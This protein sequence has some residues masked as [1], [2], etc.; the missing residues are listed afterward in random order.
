MKITIEIENSVYNT[1]GEIFK[2]AG[3]PVELY[4]RRLLTQIVALAATD[5]DVLRAIHNKSSEV[6]GY[7]HLSEQLLKP[8]PQSE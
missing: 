2:P 5:P 1:L 7:N 4:L 3:I 8:P 6:P